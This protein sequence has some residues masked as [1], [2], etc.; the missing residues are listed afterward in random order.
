MEPQQYNS[1]VVAI[2]HVWY[3][4]ADTEMKLRVG[5]ELEAIVTGLGESVLDHP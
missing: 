5:A 1:W 3:S 4:P 2:A